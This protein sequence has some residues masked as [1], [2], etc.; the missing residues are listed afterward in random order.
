MYYT[1]KENN[2]TK[3]ERLKLYDE[4][5]TLWGLVAQYDQ[6]IEEMAELTVAINKYKRKVLYGE[7]KGN[8]VAKSV[9]EEIADVSLCLEQ[10][11]YFFKD[12]NINDI[13][14]KKLLKLKDEINCMK[15]QKNI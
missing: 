5:T 15:K 3:N 2:M 12:Y 10:M 1:K 8:D 11:M 14:D 13:L 7:Y 4:A 6:C 9:V